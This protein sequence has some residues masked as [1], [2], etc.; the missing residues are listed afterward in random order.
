MLLQRRAATPRARC[1]R[2][3]TA[4]V[5]CCERCAD[6]VF[7]NLDSPG[8]A[9]AC[10]VVG[11]SVAKCEDAVSRRHHDKRWNTCKRDATARPGLR[12]VC[13]ANHRRSGRRV[14]AA[15]RRRERGAE[16]D[17]RSD[18]PDGVR[19][20]TKPGNRRECARLQIVSPTATPA[21]NLVLVESADGNARRAADAVP[22]FA[23]AT[24]RDI[25]NFEW[26]LNGGNRASAKRRPTSQIH[27]RRVRDRVVPKQTRPR[28]IVPS[29]VHREKGR[30]RAERRHPRRRPIVD[31]R[32]GQGERG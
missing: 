22:P 15:S 3:C 30:G 2:C 14:P 25:A 5:Q 13:C 17:R 9:S 4:V 6:C 7:A 16:H 8:N 20:E 26:T 32:D 12:G 23:T 10:L 21:R 19:L 1:A 29:P 28:R 31:E 18:D 24:C 27:A 11:D